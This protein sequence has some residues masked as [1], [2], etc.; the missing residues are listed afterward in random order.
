MAN[1][2]HFDENN[3]AIIS[4]EGQ[5]VG[6][7]AGDAVVILRRIKRGAMLNFGELFPHSHC[8]AGA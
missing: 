3:L 1:N 7:F 5:V 4:V 6:G 2:Y 8:V